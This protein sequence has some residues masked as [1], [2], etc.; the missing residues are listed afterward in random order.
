M[1]SW[2]PNISEPRQPYLISKPA[3]PTTAGASFSFLAL[4]YSFFQW[5]KPQHRAHWFGCNGVQGLHWDQLK[6]VLSLGQRRFSGGPKIDFPRAV[7]SIVNLLSVRFRSLWL[8]GRAQIKS[9]QSL[10]RVDYL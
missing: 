9:D 3:T 8:S 6:D 5:P 2:G 4:E 7:A 1:G 10:S